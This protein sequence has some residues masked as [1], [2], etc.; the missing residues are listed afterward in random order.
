MPSPLSCLAVGDVT[1]EFEDED[2]HPAIAIR[3]SN[4]IAATSTYTKQKPALLH[5][6]M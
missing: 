4:T 3:Y 2:K 6:T 5:A 1:L